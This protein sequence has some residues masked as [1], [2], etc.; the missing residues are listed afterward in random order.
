[1][2]DHPTRPPGHRAL[3]AG[4]RSI[5]GQPYLITI[6]TVDRIAHFRKAAVATNVAAVLADDATWHPTRAL[7]WVVMPDHIHALLVLDGGYPLDRIIIRVKALTA[8]ACNRELERR[9]PVW[10]RAFHDHALRRSESIAAAARYLIANPI[11][12]G[13]AQSVNEYPY[14]WCAWDQID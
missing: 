12:A 1:M 4:R 6:V 10:A 13:L 8:K 7:A 14:V 9:G 3:R 5:D 2:Y 11:R